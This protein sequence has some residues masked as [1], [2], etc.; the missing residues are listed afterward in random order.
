M[1]GRGQPRARAAR[2]TRFFA[3]CAPGLGRMLRRQLDAIVGVS[4]TGTGFDGRADIVF[5]E[6]DRP[7][8]DEAL[9]SRLAEDVF[10]EIGR[11]NRQ[12]APARPPWRAWP[13]SPMLSSARCRSGPRK[14]GRWQGR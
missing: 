4:A 13:G 1:T 12:A 10:A 11:A 2:R 14:S 6:A 5:F 9:Q 7:G 8:R 3:T